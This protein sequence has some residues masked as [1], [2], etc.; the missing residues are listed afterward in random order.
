MESC[1]ASGSWSITGEL[2]LAVGVCDED[3]SL[4]DGLSGDFICNTIGWVSVR[5]VGGSVWKCDARGAVLTP[6]GSNETL[7]LG[8]VKGT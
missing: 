8:F 1:S 5:T 6:S 3:D 7:N 2:P 4:T